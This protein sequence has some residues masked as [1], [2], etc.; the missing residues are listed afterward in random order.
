MIT[1]F[2]DGKCGLCAKEINYYKKTAPPGIFDWQ[3]IT[4][5]PHDLEKEGISLADGLREL[6]A[7]DDQGK[8]HVGVD[9]FILIWQQLAGWKILAWIVALPFI[10]QIV[11]FAY[12][13]FANWR[14]KRLPHCQL[15]DKV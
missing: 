14:F 7:R 13:V 9:T 15:A 5:S 3:D 8:I 10:K 2:Y 11:R 6:H 4:V 1:I 12:K